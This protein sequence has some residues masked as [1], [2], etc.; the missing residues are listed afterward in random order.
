MYKVDE[1]IAHFRRFTFVAFDPL[2]TDR[3]KRLID[4]L[5]RNGIPRITRPR[6]EPMPTRGGLILGL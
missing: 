3:I 2:T 6:N 1:K 4:D 5:Q